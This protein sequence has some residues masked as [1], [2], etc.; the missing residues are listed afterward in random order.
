M[1]IANFKDLM[2]GYESAEIVCIMKNEVVRELTVNGDTVH[3]ESGPDKVDVPIDTAVTYEAWHFDRGNMLFSLS[4]STESLKLCTEVD[5][6]RFP[7]GTEDNVYPADSII[8]R[9]DHADGKIKKLRN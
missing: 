4:G 5:K 1:K 9:R 2:A 3:I 7:D 6:I 8:T